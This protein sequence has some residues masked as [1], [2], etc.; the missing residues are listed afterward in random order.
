MN[1]TKSLITGILILASLIGTV[2][3]SGCGKNE[4]TASSDT[5]PKTVSDTA[6]T[7]SDEKKADTEAFYVTYYAPEVPVY[8]TDNIAK[9]DV[10][11]DDTNNIGL[12]LITEVTTDSSVV[13]IPNNENQLLMTSKFGYNSITIVAKVEAAVC[14][15][16]WLIDGVNYG[17]GHTDILRAGNTELTLTIR[18]VEP[19]TAE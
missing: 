16:G 6:D 18:D 3:L 4:N 14:E 13:Y 15:T 12:G 17:I 11:Y 1:K 5:E 10:L 19:A 9:G 8:V 7:S 2:S